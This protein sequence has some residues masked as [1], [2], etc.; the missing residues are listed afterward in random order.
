MS[1]LACF[2][3]SN[4]FKVTARGG[5]TRPVKARAHRP[6][7]GASRPVHTRGGPIDQ[8][9]VQLLSFL[10]C[11]NLNIAIGAGITAAAGTGLALNGSSLKGFRVVLIPITRLES[12]INQV[13]SSRDAA[14]QQRPIASRPQHRAGGIGGRAK[15]GDQTS[16]ANQP[17]PSGTAAFTWV[18]EHFRRPAFEHTRG[19]YIKGELPL[20]GKTHKAPGECQRPNKA[21]GR[22]VCDEGKNGLDEAAAHLTE[23]PLSACPACTTSPQRPA[24]SAAPMPGPCMASQQSAISAPPEQIKIG[25]GA[26]SELKAIMPS[27]RGANGLYTL[28][29][30]EGKPLPAGLG[31]QQALPRRGG[32][33]AFPEHLGGH[34]PG[35]YPPASAA[36]HSS[37]YSARHNPF[38]PI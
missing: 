32:R 29:T 11:N 14:P 38:P 2:E 18:H 9:K 22:S 16:F 25:R 13:A 31:G 10:S 19:L 4:F 21:A 30:V 8:P 28:L 15:V 34:R 3:H 17:S 20:R 12:R 27:R 36:S 7:E 5:A 33:Q 26:P 35:A 23:A 37:A 1:D 6:V 24:P